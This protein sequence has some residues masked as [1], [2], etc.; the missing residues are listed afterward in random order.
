MEPKRIKITSDQLDRILAE[1]EKRH[2][3]LAPELVERIKKFKAI[4][5]DEDT[6]SLEQT[7]D[8]FKYDQN[9]EREVEIWEWIASSYQNIR[10]KHPKL[11]K[12]ELHAAYARLLQASMEIDPVTARFEEK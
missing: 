9:P 1:Q 12:E 2:E 4:L 3:T 5:V 8:N 11:T 6:V 7:I 10:D